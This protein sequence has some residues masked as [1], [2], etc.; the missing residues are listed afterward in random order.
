MSTKLFI[1]EVSSLLNRINGGFMG[2]SGFT[3]PFSTSYFNKCPKLY[4]IVYNVIKPQ[5][6]YKATQRYMYNNPHGKGN[7]LAAV[8]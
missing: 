2:R 7:H 6:L 4:K 8:V 5:I 3:P 1:C